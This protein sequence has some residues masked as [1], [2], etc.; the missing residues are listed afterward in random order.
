MDNNLPKCGSHFL[1]K[2]KAQIYCEMSRK[3]HPPYLQISS[4]E[5]QV[6][7]AVHSFKSKQTPLMQSA[8]LG[9]FYDWGGPLR[10]TQ[11]HPLRRFILPLK[12]LEI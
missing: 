9:Y 7:S 8:N 5:I 6:I 1:Q 2:D 12:R 4:Q 10:M 3:T 11:T